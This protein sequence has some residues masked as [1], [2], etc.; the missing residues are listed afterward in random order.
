[1]KYRT[2]LIALS[3][4][5][6]ALAV[7]FL[8]SVV[9][10]PE[11]TWRRAAAGRLIASSGLSDVASV[12]IKAPASDIVLAASGGAWTIKSGDAIYPAQSGRVESFVKALLG[13]SE[14]IQVSKSKDN[15]AGFEVTDEA[16]KRVTVKNVK[17]A[18]VGDFLVGKQEPTARGIY[19]RMAGKDPVFQTP[20]SFGSY[21]QNEAKYWEYLRLL[22]EGL[23]I[24]NV[25]SFE[26]KANLSLDDTGSRKI[27]ES[28]RLVRG[29]GEAW[30]AEGRADI[31]I[32]ASKATT[33]V[34]NV[35]DF[36]AADFSAEKA[37]QAGLTAPSATV[38]LAIGNGNSYQINV[39][40][41][42]KDS[43]KF[44]LSVSGGKY[45]YLAESWMIENIVKTLDSVKA[46][47]ATAGQK[48]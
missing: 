7:L 14:L 35:L 42:I 28:Y 17:G 39:G 15:W 8:A 6:G 3:S 9:F 43:G 30:S 29:K 21:L 22:P 47:P 10:S 37:D 1:M 48:K 5:L 46:T 20:N 41:R 44:Y 38:Y 26:V 32:D 12:E 19:V 24:E 13:A 40:S 33:A 27:G 45:V 4:V 2:K 25:Q 11:N 31:S 23:K 16:A 18:V 36:E 34:R